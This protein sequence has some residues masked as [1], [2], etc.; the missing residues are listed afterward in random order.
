MHDPGR[1]LCTSII[2]NNVESAAFLRNYR[3]PAT[4]GSR[5]VKGCT[6]LMQLWFWLFVQESNCTVVAAGFSSSVVKT[7]YI[8]VPV[9]H[10]IREKKKI[11]MMLLTVD[12]CRHDVAQRPLVESKLK[13]GQPQ[14]CLFHQPGKTKQLPPNCH[15][16]ILM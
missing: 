5:I 13:H 9:L 2:K 10:P 16:Q 8:D 1:T 3:P 14:K 12:D 4:S 6:L 15:G 7:R 11:S